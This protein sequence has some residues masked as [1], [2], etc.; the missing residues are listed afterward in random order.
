MLGSKLIHV[1]EGSVSLSCEHV[2]SNAG[3]AKF[4]DS[5]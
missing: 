5:V 4:I 3:I 1:S 2:V